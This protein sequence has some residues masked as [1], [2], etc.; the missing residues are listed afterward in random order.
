[1]P[2]KNAKRKAATTGGAAGKKQS[3]KAGQKAVK[4]EFDVPIDEGANVKGADPHVF[5]D[6][7]TDTIFD[8]S[9]N[10]SNV[11]NN[12]NKVWVRR[13]AGLLRGF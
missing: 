9:L 7:D 11:S 6:D 3:K 4:R 8:A 10:Q 13:L 12:N 2:P 1:M 5:I